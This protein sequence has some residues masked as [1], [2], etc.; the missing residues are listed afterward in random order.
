MEEFWDFWNLKKKWLVHEASDELRDLKWFWLARAWS[1]YLEIIHVMACSSWKADLLIHSRIPSPFRSLWESFCLLWTLSHVVF[2]P[3]RLWLP[4]R[5][6]A[7][8]LRFLPV[9]LSALSAD[10]A[11]LFLFC[12]VICILPRRSRAP[13]T[14]L[15]LCFCPFK[16][17]SLFQL[18]LARGLALRRPVERSGRYE[19]ALQQQR[20][21]RWC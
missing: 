20:D 3:G 6:I 14:P 7:L 15:P 21:Q 1:F 13:S 18:S 10:S 12:L 16:F 5:L 17:A 2:L 9:L 4:C 8:R 19:E 11:Q